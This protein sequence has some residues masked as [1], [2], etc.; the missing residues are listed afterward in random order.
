MSITVLIADD[1]VE[2][3]SVLSSYL[4]K[5]EAI[6]VVNIA[7]DGE[8]AIKAYLKYAPDVMILDLKMPIKSGIQ[9]LDTLCTLNYA[10]SKKCNII[11]V[12][13]NLS[14]Y[15][16]QY[17]SKV[18]KVFEKPFEF[19]A[20]LDCIYEIY[21]FENNKPN[22]REIC[23]DTFLQLG[24]NYSSLGTKYLIDSLALGNF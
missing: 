3:T 8:S 21:R 5:D 6:K 19:S 2:L 22:C 4:T 17:T 11:V 10:E 15:F 14:N 1:N 13:S 12:S 16:L 20:I 7:Y 24:F 18:Y 9:V 23:E